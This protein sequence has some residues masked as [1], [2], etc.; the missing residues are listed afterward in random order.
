MMSSLL[1]GGFDAPRTPSMSRG[2]EESVE[3]SKMPETTVV[4]A[5]DS[6]GN[7]SHGDTSRANVTQDVLDIQR[8]N[9]DDVHDWNFKILNHV[10]VEILDKERVDASATDD[11]TVFVITNRIDDVRYLLMMTEGD[12]HA[13]GHL[14]DFKTFRLLQTMNKMCNKVVTDVM[15]ETTESLWFLGL[16]KNNIMRYM[17]CDKKVTN[18]P[19]D[20]SSSAPS[21][22]LGRSNSNK[23]KLETAQQS[24]LAMYNVGK[25]PLA[26]TPTASNTN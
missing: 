17:L 3:E 6:G 20:A 26:P 12:F 15:D 9:D 5:G 1:G 13:M 18:I 16:E 10:L 25:P 7:D 21:V 19:T 2:D 22:P 14:I 11:F 23:A 24:S 8:G 4:S